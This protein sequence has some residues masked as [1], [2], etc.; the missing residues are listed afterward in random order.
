MIH[1]VLGTAIGHV[2]NAYTFTESIYPVSITHS[3]TV[4][5]A[6]SDNSGH[7]YQIGENEYASNG[8]I[9]VKLGSPVEDWII[10]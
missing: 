6:S 1:I 9:W 7:V 8:Q 4:I 3:H 2:Y 10:L 5:P